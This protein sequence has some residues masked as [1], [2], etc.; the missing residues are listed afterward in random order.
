MEKIIL[1]CRVSTAH[2][3]QEQTIQVQIGELERTYK[4]RNV[5]NTYKDDGFSGSFLDRPALTQLRNDAKNGLFN[6]VAVYNLDRLSRKTVHQLLLIDEF[7]RKGI[8][9]EVLGKDFENTPQGEF[10]LTVLSAAAQ[11]E[12]ELIVQR[13][14][15]GKYRKAR[16]GTFVGCSRPIFGYKVIRKN[17][18][19]GAAGFLEEDIIQADKIRTIFKT[20]TECESLRETIRKITKLGILNNSGR[21]F[22][23]C[24][25]GY[26][27]RNETY[28]GN[29]YFGKSYSCEAKNPK[30]E[31]NKGRL[32]SKKFKAKSEWIL[33]K[34]KPIVDRALFDRVQKLL[35]ER[36][37]NSLYKAGKYQYLCAGLIRCLHCN[38]LYY[39]R[40]N[41]KYASGKTFLSYLCSGRSKPAII[42]DRCLGSKIMGVDK[43]DKA[44]WEYVS[45]LISNPERVIKSVRI[46][47]EQRDDER[48]SNQKVRDTFAEEKAKIKLKK[49]KIL[50]LYA[51]SR[52]SREDL[53]EKVADFD[54]VEKLLDKQIEEIDIKLGTINNTDSI[55]RE[56]ENLCFEHQKQILDNPDF[57]FKK[58]MIRKWVKEINIKDDRKVV[59]KVRVPEIMGEAMTLTPVMSLRTTDVNC[60][61][62]YYGRAVFIGAEGWPAFNR[63]P[64]DRNRGGRDARHQPHAFKMGCRLPVV[65][66]GNA[67]ND[68]F[69]KALRNVV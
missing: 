11:L 53:D 61:S 31:K 30:L 49:R 12:K 22:G 65:F 33:I 47:R 19:T 55:E 27:L 9:I 56:I 3:E 38:R 45:N 35:K 37:G 1:Y 4:G 10:S 21:T 59:I 42:K 68:F 23:T 67:G 41:G 2:Q 52:F 62:G 40:P 26:L 69:D 16:A 6:V 7:K 51:D 39:G 58:M 28:I 36:G 32:S 5:I 24:G 14:R 54:N 64:F 13:M 15:D 48:S 34:V 29:Y 60:Q 43:L 18:E 46:L 25:L 63:F 8:K 66:F 50:D 17:Q 20:Y 57:E 44:V